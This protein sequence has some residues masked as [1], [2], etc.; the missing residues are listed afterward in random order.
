MIRT[1]PRIIAV[2]TVFLSA[3]ATW[4]FVLWAALEVST[5]VLKTLEQIVDLAAL[6]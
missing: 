6:G 3:V 1:W 2:A 4:A 5:I